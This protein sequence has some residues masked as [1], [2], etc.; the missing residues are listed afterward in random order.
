MRSRDG[1]ETWQDSSDGLVRLAEQ[2]HLRSRLESNSESEGM[3]DG[4]ALCVSAA[5]PGAVYLAIRM[6]IFRSADGGATWRDL[7]IGRFAPY[8]YGRDIRV[9]PHDPKVLYCCLSIAAKSPEGALYRSDDLGESWRRF[10]HGIAPHS[11]MMGVA[12]DPRD[13]ARVCGVARSGLVL[14]TG[15]GGASW[16]SY[17]LPEGCEDL[18]AVACG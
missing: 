14:A 17:A 12:I 2:P 4:H 10:D 5:D 15:D 8:T 7:E 13:P 9:S 1:G 11:T 18:Y 3:L 6:G 16:H